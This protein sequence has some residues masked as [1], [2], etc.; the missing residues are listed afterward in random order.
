M[1]HP[2]QRETIARTLALIERRIRD[3]AEP[4]SDLRLTGSSDVVTDIEDVLKPLL[5]A[6]ANVADQLDLPRGERSH[7]ASAMTALSLGW[8]DLHEVDPRRL[9]RGYGFA[10][11]LAGWSE[12]RQ[13]LL[14]AIEQAIG[15]LK[16]EPGGT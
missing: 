7:R 15:R 14:D 6:L 8:T 1:R 4:R 5:D 16:T 12:A 3:A 2:D 9:Q 13:T 11:P 10:E